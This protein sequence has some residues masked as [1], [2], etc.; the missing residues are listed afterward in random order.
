MI[1]LTDFV[2][3]IGKPTKKPADLLDIGCGLCDEGEDLIRS[4]WTLTGI[5]QD[6]ETIRQVRGRM[7]DGRFIAADA[8]HWLARCEER[9]DVILIRR[10]D[11]AHR[12]ENWHRIFQLLGRLLKPGGVVFV[13]TP[14]EQEMR[15]C[16]RWLK[17]ADG[18]TETVHLGWREEEYLVRAEGLNET[19]S[20]SEP[21]DHLISELSWED[22]RPHM[23]CDLRTGR[24][25][26]AEERHLEEE[27]KQ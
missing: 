7:P 8:A 25:T 15:M 27:G 17:E 18:G 2:S 1:R 4:G 20:E 24:C 6:G 12:P 10:P 16:R 5:D 13:T 11:L 23:V 21:M 3:I 22:D 19:R 26:T 14:G 9:Y